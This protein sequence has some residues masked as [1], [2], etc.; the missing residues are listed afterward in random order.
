MSGRVGYLKKSKVGV[1]VMCRK[2]FQCARLG[3]K[4]CSD[5]CRK[6]WQRYNES[7]KRDTENTVSEV[8]QTD[9]LNA[10]IYKPENNP[11]PDTNRY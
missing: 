9:R 2:S 7:T 10:L 4:T 8:S 5:R 3:K 11:P 1:C 6:A